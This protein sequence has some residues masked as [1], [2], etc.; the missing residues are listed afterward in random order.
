MSSCGLSEYPRATK[1][2]TQGFEINSFPNCQAPKNAMLSAANTRAANP[3]DGSAGEI[4]A[5]KS[6]HQLNGSVGSAMESNT[7]IELLAIK[8][9]SF[10]RFAPSG[11]IPF[12]VIAPV[13]KSWIEAIN[14]SKTNQAEL[15]RNMPGR[16]FSG[17]ASGST[18]Y[19]PLRRFDRCD[20]L[21][22]SALSGFSEPRDLKRLRAAS[23]VGTENQAQIQ[24][25]NWATD[26]PGRF[27]NKLP[28][29][30]SRTIKGR[31]R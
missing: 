5:A 16:R 17:L 21:A 24:P 28:G 12:A 31:V 30:E 7:G 1:V 13:G 10:S 29:I 15:L 3:S 2:I 26:R 20:L 18:S 25:E 19:F 8:G 9:S 23:L 22:I 27:C 4:S 14:G 6:S 11:K